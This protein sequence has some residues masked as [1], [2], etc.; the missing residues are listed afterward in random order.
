MDEL[1]FIYLCGVSFLY[2]SIHVVGNLYL[3]SLVDMSVTGSDFHIFLVETFESFLMRSLLI[4]IPG[5]VGRER[6]SKLHFH[7]TF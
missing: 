4:L 3:S 6:D 7:K 2:I 1:L 5:F